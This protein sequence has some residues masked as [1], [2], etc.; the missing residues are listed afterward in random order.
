MAGSLRTRLLAIL[1][2]PLVGLVLAVG[3]GVWSVRQLDHTVSTL[4]NRDIP[5]ASH[6]HAACKAILE[7]RAIVLSMIIETS[8]AKREKMKVV[9]GAASSKADTELA[10]LQGLLPGDTRCNMAESTW[11]EFKQVRDSQLLELIDQG[12]VDGAVRVAAGA[13][14]E[15][16][17]VIMGSMSEIIAEAETAAA[18]SRV[19]ASEQARSAQGLTIS[20][21]ILSSIVAVIAGL[22]MVRGIVRS[23]NR[24]GGALAGLAQGDLTTCIPVTG[25][26]EVA[27]MSGRLNESCAE[28]RRTVSGI[29]QEAQG[30]ANAATQMANVSQQMSSGAQTLSSQSTTSAAAAEQISANVSTVAAGI[31]ELQASVTEI[32]SSAAQAATVAKEATTL[33]GDAAVTMQSL[34]ASS[35]E[36]GEIV[37]LITGIAEQTNLLALNATIEAARAGDAGRGFAVVASEV[38]D[39]A[40]K[41]ATA[42]TEIGS[43][44]TAIQRDSATSLES[45]NRIREI[46]GRINDQQQTIASAVEEQSATTRELA[47]SVAEVA[48]G[49]AEI[50]QTAAVV[51]GAARDSTAGSAETL[52]SAQELERL[53]SQ[54]RKRMDQF[55]V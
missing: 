2:L 43:K 35:V 11:R 3:I 10:S 23:V 26:D 12:D 19:A 51:A 37:K 33:T 49:S 24:V 8:P 54:L 44:V 9:L 4:A 17:R 30:I 53:A 42:T 21:A 45:I 18:G 52:R 50:A 15:R 55:K 14:A 32:A 48:K 29:G 46:V 27:V 1:A 38:K 6:A 20:I 39:L 22:L 41:T 5:R 47:G 31:E 40:R 36:I 7:A 34:G 28:L 16:Q 13:Q 25:H